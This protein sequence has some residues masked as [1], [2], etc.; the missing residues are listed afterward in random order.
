MNKKFNLINA[1]IFLGASL[2]LTSVQAKDNQTA[3]PGTQLTYTSPAI[4]SAGV[5]NVRNDN[6]DPSD[7]LFIF[8]DLHPDLIASSHTMTPSALAANAGGLAKVAHAIKAPSLF[9]TV[10]RNGKPGV[11]L[12]E[13]QPYATAENTIYRENADP[14]R[15]KKIVDAIKKSGKSTIIV[16]GYTS[17]VAVMLTALGAL[18]NGYRVLI[19]VDCIGNRSARTEDAA[20][21]RTVQAGAQITSLASVAAQL[22]PDF[23]RE[24]GTTILSVILDAKL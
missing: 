22:A 2:F 23:S 11:L 7:V 19:P 5:K 17:E 3:S 16:S 6:I 21:A 1:G 8:A 18:D 13:L 9:L 4:S 15:V 12:P 20:L 24:P 10:P 14:F